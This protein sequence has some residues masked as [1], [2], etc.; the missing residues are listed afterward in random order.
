MADFSGGK[1]TTV[2]LPVPAGKIT[3]LSIT[4]VPGTT[5]AIAGGYTHKVDFGNTVSAVLQYGP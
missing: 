5:E 2:K 3:F 4:A 1:L